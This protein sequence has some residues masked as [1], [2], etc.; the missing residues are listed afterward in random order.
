MNACFRPDVRAEAEPP[1]TR[2]KPKRR[3]GKQPSRRGRGNQGQLQRLGARKC[4]MDPARASPCRPAASIN[5]PHRQAGH[6]YALDRM[7]RVAE[8]MIPR[9][10]GA[11]T[12]NCP[13]LREAYLDTKLKLA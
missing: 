10:R 12:H 5:A 13:G 8:G 4:D 2:E 7:P 11:S 6:T 1:G 3:M 9:L